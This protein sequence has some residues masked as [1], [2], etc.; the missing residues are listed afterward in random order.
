MELFRR[1]AR[2]IDTYEGC[3]RRLQGVRDTDAHAAAH[4][5]APPGPAPAPAPGTP[6]V[7]PPGPAPAPAPPAPASAP[8][9]PAPAPAPGTPAVGPARSSARTGSTGAGAPVP[10]AGAGVVA[11][12][13]AGLDVVVDVVS[14]VLLS[15]PLSS[16]P[17]HAVSVNASAAAAM[18]VVTEKRRKIMR[19]VMGP[20]SISVEWD[21][22]AN[23][24]VPTRSRDQS[25][26]FATATQALV[27][28]RQA[29]PLNSRV[30]SSNSAARAWFPAPGCPR[31]TP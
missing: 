14:E 4:A 19:S 13:A 1:S 27:R 21:Y 22:L 25:R 9:G 10:G 8:P 5:P 17:P 24:E 12:V 2:R 16:P 6:A 29:I 11:V 20:I 23:G 18:P 31:S 15:S 3:Q 30:R 7:A 28:R 26:R